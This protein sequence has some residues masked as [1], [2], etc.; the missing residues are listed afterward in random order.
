MFTKWE[1][2]KHKSSPEERADIKRAALAEYDRVLAS[3]SKSGPARAGNSE[4][5][6]GSPFTENNRAS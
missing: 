5:E 2:L 4:A 6:E 1:D 3:D